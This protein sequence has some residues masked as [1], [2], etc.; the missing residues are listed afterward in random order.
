MSKIEKPKKVFKKTLANWVCDDN[1]LIFI[2]WL[3]KSVTIKFLC[4]LRKL[5]RHF[6][7][8]KYMKKNETNSSKKMPQHFIC[9][10]CDFKC[11]KQSNY[12]IH[13]LTRKHKM[14]QNETK[15]DAENADNVFYKLQCPNCLEDFNSRTT[16]WR[17][18]KKCPEKVASIN[19][20]QDQTE[21][22]QYL[23]KENSEFKQLMIEQNNK[24]FELAKNSAHNNNNTINSNNK[25]FNLQVFLNE[26]CKNAIN[27]NDFIEQ[28][29]VSITDLE[30]TGKLGFTEGISK[31]FINGLK[32]IDIP[33]R[34]LHCSDLKRE[35]IY[36][37]NN[38]EW[39]KDSDE[40]LLLVNAIKRVSNKNM[41]QITEWQKVN[42]EY[43]DSSSKINDRYLKIVSESMSGSS[44]DECDKNYKK[45]IKNIA[46][47][48]VIDK[49][50]P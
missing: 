38:N 5:F 22:V 29:Q 7:C 3:E 24:M 4:I 30:E 18:K 50:I 40:N 47:E 48:T 49:T 21:L 26:T 36:I 13:L 10:F 2:F 27:I 45:I 14:K 16:L 41:K 19:I 9:E 8:F 42:P 32:Q 28:L 46:K 31:I 23:M 37:K 25:T 39:T 6:F 34:P 33:D 12:T 17:H 1:A 11:S 43:K 20:I 15:T 35:T 44:K